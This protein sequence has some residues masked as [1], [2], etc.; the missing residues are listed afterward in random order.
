MF[1][2]VAG[3]INLYE[4]ETCLVALLEGPPLSAKAAVEA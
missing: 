1:M 3:Y 2:A 4:T